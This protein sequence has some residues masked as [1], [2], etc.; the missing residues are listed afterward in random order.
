M[1]RYTLYFVIA[2]ML[3]IGLFQSGTKGFAGQ[4]YPIEGY[5]FIFSQLTEEDELQNL[6]FTIDKNGYFYKEVTTGKY[7]GDFEAWDG[8]NFYRFSLKNNDL[9]IIKNEPGEKVI[10][11]PFFSKIVN[12]QISEDFNNGDLQKS[13]FVDKY[14]KK[15]KFGAD[16]ITETL[17]IN[18]QV[19]H[20][21]TYKKEINGKL[22]EYI[23]I[24]NLISIKDD[25]KFNSLIDL[26]KM[27]KN[28]VE[29]TEISQ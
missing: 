7:K 24:N 23:E 25:I 16:E 14:K 27:K 18:D 19:N 5:K 2:T 17:E 29:I 6:D 20:P 8:L 13:P 10:S 11:H 3:I 1:K 28:N 9:L 12:E 21:E 4:L 22:Q 15:F 26:D